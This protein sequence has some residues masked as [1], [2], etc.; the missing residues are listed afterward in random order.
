M[1]KLGSFDT[2]ELVIDMVN[3]KLIHKES[4]VSVYIA[5]GLTRNARLMALKTAVNSLDAIYGLYLI[6]KL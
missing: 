6:N 3:S 5:N 1:S 4:G 2:S